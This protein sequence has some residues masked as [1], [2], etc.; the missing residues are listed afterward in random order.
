MLTFTASL[1]I[2]M[3]VRSNLLEHEVRAFSFRYEGPCRMAPSLAYIE[4]TLAQPD[5]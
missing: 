5:A 2:Q 3:T 4:R 1:Y